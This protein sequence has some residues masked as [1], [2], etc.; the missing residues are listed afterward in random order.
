[1]KIE[2]EREKLLKPLGVVASVVER[3]QTLP[4]LANILFRKDAGRLML[5]GTDLEIEVTNTIDGVEGQDGAC[6][7]TA[8]KMVDIC[9]AL[10][11]GAIIKLDL[12]ADKAVVRS[13]R[14][15]FSL[16]V[17]AAE[18]FPTLETEQ[19]QCRFTTPQG[20]LKRLLDQTAFSM[21]HQD[22]R[23]YLNGLLFDIVNSSLC[24]VAT[25]GH[26]LAKGEIAID[27]DGV[28]DRQAIIPRK[29]VLEIS[30]FLEDTDDP[31]EV[32]LNPN[33]IRFV[34]GSSVFTSKLID[35]RFPDY[36]A[37]MST[38]LPVLLTM[39]RGELHE[40]LMRASILTNEKFRGVR[41]NIGDGRFQVTAHNPEQEEATDEMPVDYSGDEIEIGF[42][43]NYL[44]DALK[45]LHSDDVEMR[46]QDG[47]S[48]CTFNAPGDQQTR[49][50]VMPMRL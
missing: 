43:V 32:A 25:D 49:Y 39:N 1:M 5:T 27:G 44:M 8:R 50:L 34:C 17:L 7:V 31:V 26:R 4:I 28:D 33:H 35:G 9:R 21:A 36:K 47:N 11:E 37:V 18:D 2:L 42:N 41:I 20:R 22:V 3:R 30:R 29:A 16:Q 24:A 10:P 48:S 13:G 15:R 19:W 23:Y 38:M 12:E 46:L 6:T 40:T 45:A 14:S